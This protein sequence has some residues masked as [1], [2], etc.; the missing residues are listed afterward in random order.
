M[1][2]GHTKNKPADTEGLTAHGNGRWGASWAT[3]PGFRE[4]G[5]L[6]LMAPDRMLMP[7]QP[8]TTR[9]TNRGLYRR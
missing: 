3:R 4:Q 1:V 8:L 7:G 2:A 6:R 9:V 5:V